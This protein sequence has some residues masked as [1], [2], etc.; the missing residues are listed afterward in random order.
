MSKTGW[1]ASGED[2]EATVSNQATAT[3]GR[4]TYETNLVSNYTEVDEP[5]QP[6]PSNPQTGD[7]FNVQLWV[8]LLMTSGIGL[9]ATVVLGRKKE[10]EMA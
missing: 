5:D 10:N 7:A 9:G 8:L 1:G 2:G 3:D 6:G 4:N